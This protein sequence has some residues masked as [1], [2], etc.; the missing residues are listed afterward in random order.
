MGTDMFSRNKQTQPD[1]ADTLSL[2][3][4]REQLQQDLAEMR[5]L[6][7]ECRAT[8]QALPKP[9]IPAGTH[10]ASVPQRYMHNY[11]RYL[12][13][14]GMMR[15]EDMAGYVKNNT[16]T[17]YDQ[18][19][20]YFLCLAADLIAAD[21]LAG[22]MAELGVY[23]G[24]TASVLARSAEHLG[25]KIYL[26]DTFEGFNEQDMSA[27]EKANH[28]DHF[29][30]SSLDYVKANVAGAHARFVQGRFP[31]TAAQIP[32]D[33]SFC[34]VHLDCDLYL[35]FKS[36]LEYFW[37]RI[38]G[39]GFLIMHDYLSMY[40]DGVE[41]AVTEFFAN[42]AESIVPIPDA[43]GTVVIRKNK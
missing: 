27:E 24:N 43:S 6:L 29:K 39:G 33:A 14:G 16:Q 1:Y 3:E 26:L 32:A 20:F 22:D 9:S 8:M 17:S 7:Q 36:A 11:R 31:E 13:R 10:I 41:Q 21:K 40:W 37:P 2:R 19:R 42:K 23:K 28:D 30:D 15:H 4:E 38:V 18:T 12:E 5:M 25:K 35:P 34:L